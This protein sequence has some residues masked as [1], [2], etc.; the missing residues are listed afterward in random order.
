M[1]NSTT[2]SEE[3]MIVLSGG[4]KASVDFYRAV[5][6]QVVESIPKLRFGREYRSQDL[7]DPAFW[8][9]GGK[10]VHQ[11]MGKCVAHLVAN[12]KVALAFASCPRCS[13]KRYLR[14]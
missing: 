10:G 14:I 9:C 7:I 5:Q 1:T 4:R 12:G 2:A 8:D 11:L 6:R 13:N 3:Q